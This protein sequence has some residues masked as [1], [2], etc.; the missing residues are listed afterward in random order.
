M[1]DD[2]D[3]RP[4]MS[5]YDQ[6]THQCWAGRTAE[7]SILSPCQNTAKSSLGLCKE[8]DEEIRP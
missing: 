3:Y 7:K 5:G 8:H 1:Q 4:E 2:E 6:N